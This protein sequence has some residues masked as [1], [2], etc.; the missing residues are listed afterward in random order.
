MMA[1]KE[2]AAVSASSASTRISDTLDWDAGAGSQTMAAYTRDA[3]TNFCYQ[4]ASYLL[5]LRLRTNSIRIA[6]SGL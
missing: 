5:A 3:N 6:Q 4:W 2:M 1:D